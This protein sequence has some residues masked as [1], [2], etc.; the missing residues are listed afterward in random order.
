MGTRRARVNHSEGR[1]LAYTCAYWKDAETLGE[2]Q[3]AKLDLV[4]RKPTSNRV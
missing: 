2:A 3:E 1:R 4:C